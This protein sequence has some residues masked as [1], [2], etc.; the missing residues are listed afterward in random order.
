MK[1]GNT[2]PTGRIRAQLGARDRKI[3]ADLLLY[4]LVTNELMGAR[5]LPVSKANAVTKVSSRLVRDGWL[6]P[7]NLFDKR[8]YFVPG[9]TLV[10]HFGL[11]TSRTRPLGTQTLAVQLALAT[12]CITAEPVL[13]LVDPSKLAT[14]FPWL[15]TP[16]RKLPHVLQLE[17][18]TQPVRLIRVDLGGTPDH[19]ALKAKRDIKMREAVGGYR[20]LLEARRL[21]LVVI[22]STEIKSGLIK[23]AIRKRDWPKNMRFQVV[24]VD[25][26][27]TL[28]GC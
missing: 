15:P 26:L 24:V 25:D 12:Y 5:H 22:T 11:P 28:L 19:V 2:Q 3:I 23:E 18:P 13:S 8:L 17:D 21:T 4:R 16:L 6:T 20:A 7:Y 9:K 1:S 14:A 10:R 27:F